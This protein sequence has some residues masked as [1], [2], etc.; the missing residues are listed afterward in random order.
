MSQS[1]TAENQRQELLGRLRAA[2][3]ALRASLH[4]HKLDAIVCA[5]L[6]R[7]LAHIQ[8]VYVGVNESVRIRTVQQ[9]ADELG[10]VQQL[11]EELRQQPPPGVT[12]KS[13]K[14]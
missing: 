1:N 12:V 14:P 6:E 4:Q 10:K 11:C 3:T 13:F 8:E 7:A 9:L 2:D 5:H